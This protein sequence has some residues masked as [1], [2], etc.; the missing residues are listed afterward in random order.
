VPTWEAPLTAADAT[1]CLD[2][3]YIMI[4]LGLMSVEES[5]W[6]EVGRNFQSPVGT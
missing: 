5:Y 6:K 1:F 3:T 4:V 2:S